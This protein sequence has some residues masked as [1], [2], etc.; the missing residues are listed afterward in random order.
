MR[1][2]RLFRK[3]LK[4]Q[5]RGF[6]CTW[7]ESLLE[8][9]VPDYSS[10]DRVDFR[11][12][13]VVSLKKCLN[14]LFTFYLF[15][16]ALFIQIVKNWLILI[17]L[18]SIEFQTLTNPNRILVVHWNLSVNRLIKVFCFIGEIILFKTTNFLWYWIYFW[19]ISALN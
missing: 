18:T 19:R 3:S 7:F 1:F 10:W 12:K 13:I 8:G 11:L 17:L 4:P 5:A 2:N 9:L 14:V 6:F 16:F 15:C